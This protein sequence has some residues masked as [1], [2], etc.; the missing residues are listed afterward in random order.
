MKN[1]ITISIT[2]D[3][4]KQV[5]DKIDND[6]LK[7]RSNVIENL[8]RK[9]L[10]LKEDVWALI[11]AHDRN[12]EDSVFSLDIPKVLIKIDGKSLLEKHLE[13]LKKA[14]VKNIVISLWDKKEQIIDFIESKNFNLNI[15]FL[16]V[17]Q[18]DLSLRV[19]GKAKKLLSTNKMLVILWDNYFYPLN[20][21]DFIYYHNSNNSE[22]SIIVKN[23]KSWFSY[24]NIQIQWND[25]VE[26]NEKPQ[27][28]ENISNLVNTWIYL[29]DINSIPDTSQNLKIESDFFPNFVKNKK[30]KAYFHN[31]KWFHMQSN[32]VLDLFK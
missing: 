15:V 14:N 23:V 28:K 29:I 19:I 5:D 1:K 13:N 24:W 3:I 21:T 31:W 4:L 17:L 8:L 30:V 32:K 16:E 2:N 27:N 25:V 20:L 12:W 26:F 10:N 7:N 22:F 11:L 6:L 9:W 18:T